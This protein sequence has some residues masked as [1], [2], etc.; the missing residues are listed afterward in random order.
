[1]LTIV[2]LCV[3]YYPLLSGR[4]IGLLSWS[5]V[6]RGVRHTFHEHGIAPYPGDQVGEP[7]AVVNMLTS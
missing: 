1:M 7:Y 3:T 2:F 4:Y 6:R 5:R